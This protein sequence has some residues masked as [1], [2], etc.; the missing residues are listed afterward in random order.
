MKKNI[1]ILVLLGIMFFVMGI[2]VQAAPKYLKGGND[3]KV[4]PDPIYKKT[5]IVPA[6]HIISITTQEAI[7]STNFSVPDKVEVNLNSD[8]YYNKVRIAPEGSLV[9][10]TVVRSFKAT[11]DRDAEIKVK[12]TSIITPD[13]Q[14]IPISG[15]FNTKRGT[16][17]GVDGLKQNSTYN[18]IIVQPVTYVPF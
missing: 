9:T 12:F 3:K 15:L 7:N 1:F 13:G 4:M 17:Y 18:I 14:N 16:I 5:V 2:E 8:F 11:E 10:G 6:G